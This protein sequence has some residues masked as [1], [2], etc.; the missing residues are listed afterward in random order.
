MTLVSVHVFMV[1]YRFPVTIESSIQSLHGSELLPLFP[2]SPLHPG[3]AGESLGMRLLN[4]LAN[5]THRRKPGNETAKQ[6]GNKTAEQ[7]GQHHRVYRQPDCGLGLGRC[8]GLWCCTEE[9][10]LFCLVL[11][12]VS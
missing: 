11:V 1:A 5:A 10:L 2:G 4:S 9:M 8:C 12:G 3:E 6:P 7:P